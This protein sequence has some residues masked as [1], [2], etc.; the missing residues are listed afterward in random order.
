MQENFICLEFYDPVNNEVMSN[1]SDDSG[2]G[3]GQP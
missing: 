3:P 2:I 1:R